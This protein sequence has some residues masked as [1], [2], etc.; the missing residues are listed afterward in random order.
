MK[1]IYVAGGCFWGVEAYF[2]LIPGIKKT[3]VG[4]ANSRMK[5]PTYREVCS[6]RTNAV[7]AVELIYNPQVI[8]LEQLLKFFYRIIDPTLLNRQGGDIGSQYRT[9]IYYV[10][11]ND[12]DVIAN[13]LTALQEEYEEKVVVETQELVN[14]FIAEDEHQDYL[15][16]NPGGYCHVNMNV[17][18][19][20][21][22]KI[23]K[24]R[25][26]SELITNL[27]AL[28]TETVHPLSVLSNVAALLK[29]TFS[30][31]SWVGFYLAI[32]G[33]LVV[34]PFQG[35]VACDTIAFGK[36]VCGESF[37]TQKV[38]IIPD[39]LNHPNHIACESETRSEIVV[40]LYNSG[41][42]V[43]GVLD[44]DSYKYDAFDEDDKFYLTH[45]VHTIKHYFKEEF[46]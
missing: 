6:G 21:E 35:N 4:Y 3:A 31:V 13:S 26:Y 1:K 46:K 9:G 22:R 37:V 12:A 19:P 23:D 15:A 41:D 38:M 16:Q 7:E 29:A 33:K 32:D 39:V 5:N 8:T 43:I 10:D 40:P 30:D 25:L 44:L 34:G 11:A 27:R 18:A 42:E 24:K 28:L 20:H 2:K 17:L 36:G 45:I 14:F